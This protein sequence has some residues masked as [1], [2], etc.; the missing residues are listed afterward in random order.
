MTYPWSILF[1]FPLIYKFLPLV[2]NPNLLCFLT[3]FCK[4]DVAVEGLRMYL[5]FWYGLGM[6]RHFR[7]ARSSRWS[8]GEWQ[9]TLVYINPSFIVIL[10]P[11]MLSL[12]ELS[13][14]TFSKLTAYYF[15]CFPHFATFSVLLKLDFYFLKFGVLTS[16]FQPFLRCL[17]T[18]NLAFV[19]WSSGTR[20]QH[21]FKKGSICFIHSTLFEEHI[22]VSTIKWWEYL[23]EWKIA[24]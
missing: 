20:R 12:Q 14:P 19:I 11:S 5:D 17:L 6:V 8:E 16:D 18:I 13:Y 24:I 23:H 22:V 10:Q 3:W 1:F 9:E 2:N 4:H 7:F 15:Y 21:L